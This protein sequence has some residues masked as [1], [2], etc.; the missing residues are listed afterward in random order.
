MSNA[1]PKPN[2]F[3]GML[4]G[5]RKISAVFGPNELIIN[6]LHNFWNRVVRLLPL[7]QTIAEINMNYITYSGNIQNLSFTHLGDQKIK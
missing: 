6:W 2:S 7:E 3:A 4:I 1:F 5:Y